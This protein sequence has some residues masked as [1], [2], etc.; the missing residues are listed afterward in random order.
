MI[1]RIWHGHTTHENADVYENLL[2]TEIFPGIEKKN[3][4]GYKSIQLLRRP[5]GNEIEFITIMTF[6]SIE[7][8]NAFVGNDDYSTSYVPAKARELLSHFDATAQHYD[9]KEHLVYL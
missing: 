8:V 4:A 1:A 3:V 7:A 9:I 2:K 5:R 6:E